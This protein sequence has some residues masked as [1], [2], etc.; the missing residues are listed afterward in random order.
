M[1]ASG[2]PLPTTIS[3]SGSSP[4]RH[5]FFVLLEGMDLF[6]L[7]LTPHSPLEHNSNTHPSLESTARAQPVAAD[8]PPPVFWTCFLP[9]H[10][11]S[12]QLFCSP[13]LYDFWQADR[14][15]TSFS[16]P[17]LRE[18]YW[19]CVWL[20]STS[21]IHHAKLKHAS[22]GRVWIKAQHTQ[23]KAKWLTFPRLRKI[24]RIFKL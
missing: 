1:F 19:S 22:R 10:F 8:P 5:S 14:Y 24:V 23:G 18:F 20:L 6:S 16:S 15:H 11:D 4:A 2:A 13:S 3:S 21:P 12:K 17:D 7:N 9:H